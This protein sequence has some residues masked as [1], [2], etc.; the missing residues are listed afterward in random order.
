MKG[1]SM[2]KV[3]QMCDGCNEKPVDFFIENEQKQR[4]NLCDG[5]GLRL[6]DILCER[7]KKIKR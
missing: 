3:V 1:I 2:G 5:C 4:L 7:Y 6:H